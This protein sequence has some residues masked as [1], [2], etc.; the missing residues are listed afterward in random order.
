MGCRPERGEEPAMSTGERNNSRAAIPHERS[1]CVIS[2][3]RCNS[4]AAARHST[5]QTATATANRRGFERI[6]RIVPTRIRAPR[7]LPRFEAEKQERV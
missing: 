4:Y 2:T 7:A 5:L 6:V 1:E 3:G